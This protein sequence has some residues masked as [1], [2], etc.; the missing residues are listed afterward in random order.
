MGDAALAFEDLE[1]EFSGGRTEVSALLR[2]IEAL[3]HRYDLWKVSAA[4]GNSGA[5]GSGSNFGM[6]SVA[7]AL[8]V[9][10]P[11]YGNVPSSGASQMQMQHGAYGY[12]WGGTGTGVGPMGQPFYPN[13]QQHGSSGNGGHE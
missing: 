1:A 2:H 9:Y 4:V 6:G 7:H 8:P 5:G 3:R 12:A 10:P 13:Q 11:G